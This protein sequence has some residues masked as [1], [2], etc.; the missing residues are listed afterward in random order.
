MFQLKKKVSNCWN[1][2]HVM[3]RQEWAMYLLDIIAIE[4][5]T[6][7]MVLLQEH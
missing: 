2:P 3:C 1:S 5:L 7:R 4:L 6:T